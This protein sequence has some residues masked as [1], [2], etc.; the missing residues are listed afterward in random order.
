MLRLVFVASA[1][2]LVPSL[3]LIIVACHA[4][5]CNYNKSYL[6]SSDNQLSNGDREQP[7]ERSS[8]ILE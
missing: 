8:R 2:L 4:R 3:L 1:R 5:G 7:N 6:D